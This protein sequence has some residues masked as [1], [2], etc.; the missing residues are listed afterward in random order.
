MVPKSCSTQ[1]LKSQLSLKTR[2]DK[3][4]QEKKARRDPRRKD[5]FHYQTS[6]VFLLFQSGPKGVTIGVGRLGS[7]YNADRRPRYSAVEIPPCCLSHPGHSYYLLSIQQPGT[8]YTV[9]LN[10][11]YYHLRTANYLCLRMYDNIRVCKS[12]ST[13]H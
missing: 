8:S 6:R 3:K 9:T 1:K 7:L 11:V 12:T 4:K 13:L 2:Q 5:V 10:W